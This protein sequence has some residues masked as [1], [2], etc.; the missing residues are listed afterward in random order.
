MATPGRHADHGYGDGRRDF[1][2]LRAQSG[3]RN[4]LHAGHLDSAQRLECLRRRGPAAVEPDAGLSGVG[5][6]PTT[7]TRSTPGSCKST[8]RSPTARRITHS[9]TPATAGGRTTGIRRTSRAT[10]RR[11]KTSFKARP[12]GRRC[13]RWTTPTR[14]YTSCP[15]NVN[16]TQQLYNNP[17][18][19]CLPF[20]TQT[21][22]YLGGGSGS[23]TVP[24]ETVTC[25]YDPLLLV[26]D[27]S[28][29]PPRRPTTCSPTAPPTTAAPS[30][31]SP[32]PT[33]TPDATGRPK[34]PAT[35]YYFEGLIQSQTVTDNLGNRWTCSQ[36]LYDTQPGSPGAALKDGAAHGA[37]RLQR[38]RHQRQQLHAERARSPRGPPTTASAAPS[39]RPTPTR[40]RA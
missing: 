26:H 13:M 4:E 34:S 38:L 14:T 22:T 9:T 21:D 3:V 5:L 33:A 27:G 40:S 18:M 11:W 16:G 19:F 12:A 6:A 8:P 2:Q 20:E 7:T 35:P 28:I 30:R 29:P 31:P 15:G 36:T 24:H 37:D 25:D 39:P 1:L 17:Y 23:S 10:C 32:L